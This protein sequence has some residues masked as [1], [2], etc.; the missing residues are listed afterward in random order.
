MDQGAGTI[1]AEVQVAAGKVVSAVW[2][3]V[4]PPSYEPPETG[5]D[6]EAESV[7]RVE[8]SDP[9]EDGVY[10]G[11]YSFTEPT[12]T[13]STSFSQALQISGLMNMAGTRSA[14]I[15]SWEMC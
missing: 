9:D 7:P 5:E 8:L 6:L 3:L 15:A 14:G 13:A 10:T 4:Y 1:G 2:A 11:P 12:A